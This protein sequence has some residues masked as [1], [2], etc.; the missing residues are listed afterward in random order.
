VVIGGVI[1][2]G[3]TVGFGVL[4]LQTQRRIVDE[5]RREAEAVCRPALKDPSG[6]LMGAACR[7][8]VPA[9]GPILKRVRSTLRTTVAPSPED[10]VRQQLEPARAR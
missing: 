6:S 10:C 5:T 2:L 7:W 4:E 1:G 8:S 3:L 9:A